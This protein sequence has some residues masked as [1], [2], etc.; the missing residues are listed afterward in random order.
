M[1]Q[2]NKINSKNGNHKR[3]KELRILG[4]QININISKLGARALISKYCLTKSVA[5]I[6]SN[7]KCLNHTKIS[8]ADLSKYNFLFIKML[9]YF[10][11]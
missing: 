3:Y 1:I 11:N 2:I 6:F 10:F 4:K 5:D 9:P 8:T 7:S